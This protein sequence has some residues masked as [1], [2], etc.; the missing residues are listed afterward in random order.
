MKPGFFLGGLMAKEPGYTQIPHAILEHLMKMHLS[1][2]Q[3]QVLLCIFRKTYGF[4]K[5]VD[6]IANKQIG[7]DTGLCKTV[8][9]RAL[10]DL[11]DMQ[12]IS[13]KGKHIGVQ[14]DW[15]KWRELA[16]QST[17]G[18]KLAEQSTSLDNKSKQYSQ[19]KL[20]VLSTE[21]AEQS[22]K[23]SS[24]RGTQKIKDTIS[25]D[26]I[27]NMEG[28]S[29]HLGAETPA[30]KYLFEKTGRKRWANLVQKEQFEKA[31][32]EVG[33]ARVKEA[34]D[35]ALTSGISNIKSI[36]TAARRSKHATHRQGPRQL[37]PRDSYTKP[38]DY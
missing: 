15:G 19:P 25:K 22:T 14:E 11:N 33:E 1:P 23:V 37:R 18:S 9:S 26:T 5:K 31:E 32:S 4:H 3:W 16:K 35:W 13:R 17:L 12:L 38:E 29:P 21:L 2:N 20:A 24:P 10:H 27:Q 34:I 6:Y 7:E 30:S 36:I 28:P 8:V